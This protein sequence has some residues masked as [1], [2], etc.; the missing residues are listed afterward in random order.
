MYKEKQKQKNLCKIFFFLLQILKGFI[1][2]AVTTETCKT[3]EFG[4]Q[5]WHF[6]E[7]ISPFVQNV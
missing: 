4:Q 6:G 5:Q 7:Q 2:K 1:Y 3:A